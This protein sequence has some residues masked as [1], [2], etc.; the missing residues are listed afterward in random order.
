MSVKSVPGCLGA[1]PPSLI[2]APPAFL[3]FHSPHLDAAAVCDWSP[4]V[5]VDAELELLELEPPLPPPHAATTSA[6][7]SATAAGRVRTPRDPRSML[8]AAPPHGPCR[9]RGWPASNLTRR[10]GAVLPAGARLLVD[11][12]GPPTSPRPTRRRLASRPRSRTT[13]RPST[14]TPRRP[15]PPARARSGSS[16]ADA[17]SPAGARA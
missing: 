4:P 6:A 14:A 2:R 16:P 10:R 8:T 3:P 15:P 13:P 11:S 7:A 12:C 17:G 1:T 5:E 9:F